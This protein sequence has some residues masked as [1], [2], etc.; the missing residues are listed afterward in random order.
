LKKHSK[1]NVTCSFNLHEQINLPTSLA[2][3]A[4]SKAGIF[5][6]KRNIKA[7]LKS[8]RVAAEEFFA[9]ASQELIGHS[10]SRD[11]YGIL[12]TKSCE[13]KVSVLYNLE[14]SLEMFMILT[15]LNPNFSDFFILTLSYLAQW[16]EDISLWFFD[17]QITQKNLDSNLRFVHDHAFSLPVLSYLLLDASFLKTGLLNNK[18]ITQK[19]LG[20]HLLLVFILNIYL[21][22]LKI[23]LETTNK[24]IIYHNYHVTVRELSLLHDKEI[25]HYFICFFIVAMGT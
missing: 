16:Q 7:E 15:L 11:I 3:R 6:S 22:F 23:L 9:K 24:L 20:V 5:L 2:E 25:I 17:K 4:E 18:Q 1:R 8:V 13:D 19:N 12:A 14:K 21:L 10:D